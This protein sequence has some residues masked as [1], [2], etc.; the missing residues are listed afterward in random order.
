M[1]LDKVYP[2]TFLGAE[3]YLGDP[4]TIRSAYS[5]LE[6]LPVDS[7]ETVERWCGVWSEITSAISEVEARAYF[8]ITRDTRNKEAQ[9]EYER[10]I[11]EVMPLEEELDEKAKKRFLSIPDELVP[12]ELDIARKNAQWAVELFREENLPLISENMKLRNNYQN[13]SS[14]W[15]TEFEGEMRTPKQIMP[16]LEK[17]D[18][19]MRERAWK[20]IMGIY[21]DDHGKLNS[22][23]DDMLKTRRQMAKNAEVEDYVEY[24]YRNYQRLSYDRHDAEQFR[25][26]IHKYVVPVVSEIFEGIK[27]KQELDSIRPWDTAMDPDGAE[28]PKVYTDIED[29]KDKVAAVLKK[30]DPQF[31]EGFRLMDS[32]GYLDLENRQGK[33]TGAYMNSFAEE[34]ISMIFANSAGTGRDFDTLLHE[35]GHAMHGFLCRHL[36]LPARHVPLEFCEV[37]AMAL[38]LLSRPYLDLVYNDDDRERIG[39]TKLEKTLMFLPFMSMLDEFQNWVYTSHDGGDAEARADYWRGL[40]DKYRPHIDWSGL[41]KEKGRGWQYNHVFTV[42]LYYIEYGIAQVG[43]LQVFLN[44]LEDWDGAFGKYRHALSLGTTVGL[45]ELYEAAGVKFVMKHPEALKD[46][47]D[48]MLRLIG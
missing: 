6:T 24:Q 28:P 5:R 43:A 17:P 15:E 36:L 26:A 18:R 27:K 13:I 47:T 45:A 35:S 33:A 1:E 11:N 29:L 7:E 40:E 2:R 14:E 37:A 30:V 44:S 38:E 34:R 10:L 9:A 42:P 3:E 48:G 16:F 23:F 4:E 32:R 31:E 39:R 25:E 12:E 20:A 41:E 19:E 22:L 21:L 46:V 8:E